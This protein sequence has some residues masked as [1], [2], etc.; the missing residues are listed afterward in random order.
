MAPLS[1][2][3][4]GVVHESLPHLVVVRECECGCPSFDMADRR[5]APTGPGV[6]HFSNGVLPDGRGMFLLVDSDGRPRSIDCLLG[7]ERPD[8][9]PRLHDRFKPGSLGSDSALPGR[10]ALHRGRWRFSH[11]RCA[12]ASH[13]LAAS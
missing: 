7:Y 1:L 6:Q 9:R 11:K 13:S 4:A 5:S 8:S 10:T 2:L 3:G 12:P